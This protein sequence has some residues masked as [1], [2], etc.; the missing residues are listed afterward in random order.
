VPFRADYYS[1][2]T[3]SIKTKFK[4]VFSEV[5]DNYI[6]TVPVEVPIE[7]NSIYID[8]YYECD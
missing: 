8:P 3:D 7:Y 2:L 5:E 6:L 1:V 4:S